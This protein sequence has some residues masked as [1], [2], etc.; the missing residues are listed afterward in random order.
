MTPSTV[1]EAAEQP[2]VGKATKPASSAGAAALVCLS[3]VAM[4]G[5]LV[6][7]SN[8]TTGVGAI[9]VACLFGIFA[10]IAQAGA[11]HKQVVALLDEARRG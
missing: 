8:A 6:S 1:M 3:V 5:G 7:L 10:R 2:A 11:Q 9:C 4:L